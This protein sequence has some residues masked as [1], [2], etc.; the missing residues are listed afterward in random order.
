MPQ[1]RCVRIYGTLKMPI[2]LSVAVIVPHRFSGKNDPMQAK[3]NYQG[4]GVLN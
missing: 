1:Q 3:H 4:R 2:T